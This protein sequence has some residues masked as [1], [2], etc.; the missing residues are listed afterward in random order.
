MHVPSGKLTI[1]WKITMFNGKIHYKWPFS[2][3]MLN[4]HR[5]NPNGLTIPWYG[6][7][8]ETK[9]WR[10]FLRSIAAQDKVLAHALLL[11]HLCLSLSTHRWFKMVIV[12]LPSSISTVVGK[13]EFIISISYK[14]VIFHCQVK[15]IAGGN[16][17]MQSRFTS[18]STTEYK[19]CP[20][21][22]H[23]TPKT[24]RKH[25]S[26]ALSI[27]LSLTIYMFWRPCR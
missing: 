24:A 26:P 8:S 11:Q 1:L 4:Y 18:M 22:W 14:W 21:G 19:N 15:L 13:Y 9:N 3:A 17:L 16:V 27:S 7:T 25:N 10:A 20:E 12:F 2:I 23:G 6:Y 5:V